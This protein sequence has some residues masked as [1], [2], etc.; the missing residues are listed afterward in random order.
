[1]VRSRGT[2]ASRSTTPSDSASLADLRAHWYGICGAPGE[3]PGGGRELP[4]PAPRQVAGPEWQ[5]AGGRRPARPCPGGAGSRRSQ[6]QDLAFSFTE[7]AEDWASCCTCSALSCADVLTSSAAVA[8]ESLS[9]EPT[10]CA[11]PLA[12]S[13]RGCPCS[14]AASVT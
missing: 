8:A 14:F 12:W 13:T 6:A 5:C 1:M 10:S 4:R 7:S 11:T 9:S 3:A 2:S